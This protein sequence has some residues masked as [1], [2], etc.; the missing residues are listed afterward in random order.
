MFLVISEEVSAHPARKHPQA[1]HRPADISRCETR[2]IDRQ[3]ERWRAPETEP[4]EGLVSA[5]CHGEQI[6]ATRAER[7]V[8]KVEVDEAEFFSVGPDG[9]DDCLSAIHPQLAPGHAEA[10]EA[11]RGLQCSDDELHPS[12]FP[13]ND[14]E[15]Q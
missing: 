7:V 11:P 4:R 9:R 1:F 3:E 12:P 10:P 2:S 5:Q 8:R 6:P 14:R 13:A 15:Q